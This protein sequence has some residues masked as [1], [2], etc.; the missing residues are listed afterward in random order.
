VP[1]LG[2]P[3]QP[4]D[5]GERFHGSIGRADLRCVSEAA[6][7]CAA[8]PDRYLPLRNPPASGLNAV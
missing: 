1:L 6:A 5:R 8:S 3:P 7:R 4:F 2:R